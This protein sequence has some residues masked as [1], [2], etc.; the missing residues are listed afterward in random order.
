MR[1]AKRQPHRG[2][3]AIPSQPLEPVIA[4]HLE[5]AAEAG[6]VF[7]RS[8][9]LAVLGIHISCR[10]GR[11]AAPGSLVDRVAP[12]VAGLRPAATGIEHRQRRVIGK[13]F[14][15]R[16]HRV[17]HQFVEWRQPPAGAPNPIAQR[18]A[19]QRNA[20]PRQHL[21]L[22]VERQGIAELAD[23]H[24]HHQRLSGHAA[25][26]GPLRRRGDHHGPLAAA[27]GIAGPTRDTHAK[28]GRR[29]V[30]LFG[31]QFA[32]RV[33]G[34]ATT[35]AV[36][37]L[38]V[39]HHLV[40]RQMSRQGTMIAVGPRCA[41]R[42][43]LPR[44]GRILCGLVLGDRLLEVLQSELELIPSELF[45]AAAKLMTQQA[46]DQPPQL[47][48]L[49]VQF[50][51]L[52]H[53]RPQ[54]LLQDGRIVRQRV[55][56]NLHDVIMNNAPA[57]MPAFLCGGASFTPPTPACVELPERATHT[58]RAR[59]PIVPRTA[60]SGRSWWQNASGIALVRASSSACKGQRRHARS[61]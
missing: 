36:V 52:M 29:D 50:T 11:R 54:H 48:V 3:G 26:N 31:A 61:T 34:A 17:E 16:Q 21:R 4:V 14:A 32:D 30:Q 13:Q 38:H 47:V 56:V 10:W 57:S 58:R 5:H 51:L 41:P 46:L 44:G 55:E 35:R 7:G 1:P 25:I 9:V 15:R 43:I 39:D 12:K 28:L 18:R 27:A 40:A 42:L 60:R 23:H 53:H 24:V 22:A 37:V 33:Q 49:G 19:I 59:P 8:R 45:R 20:L 2:I 6:Q